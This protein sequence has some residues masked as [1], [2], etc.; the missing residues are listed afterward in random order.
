MIVRDAMDMDGFLGDIESFPA[1]TT[2]ISGR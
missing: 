2:A 1:K